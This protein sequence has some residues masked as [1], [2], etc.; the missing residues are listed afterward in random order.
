MFFFCCDQLLFFKFEFSQTFILGR[1]V[2]ALSLCGGLENG[3]PTD[4][5]FEQHLIDYADVCQ[6][7]SIF[8]SSLLVVRLCDKYYS[9]AA[10]SSIVMTAIAYR[11]PLTHVSITII[12][13]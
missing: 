2:I 6:N 12:K 11:K 1:N 10:A 9:W 8:M 3:G 7:P 4:E 5:E 13:S